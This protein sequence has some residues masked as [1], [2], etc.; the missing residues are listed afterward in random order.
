M[1]TRTDRVEFFPPQQAGLV[2][3]FGLAL[4]AHGLLLLALTWGVNWKRQ[5][6]D[7]VAEAEL[8][9]AIPQQAAPRPAPPPEP[10][11]EPPAPVPSPAPVPEP[12]PPAPAPAPEPAP[13][14]ADIALEQIKQKQLR[15]EALAREAALKAQQERKLKAEQVAKREAEQRQIAQQK[16]LLDKA[17]ADKA[18]EEKRKLQAT[19][20]SA[21]QAKQDAAKL[22]KEREEQLRRIMSQ[23]G[24]VASPGTGAQSATGTAPRSSGPSDSYEARVQAKL[25]PNIVF[26]DNI[27]GNPLADVEVRAA[28]DGTI[29]ARRLVRSSGNPA[30]DEA[31]LKAIDKTEV[32]PKDVDGRVPS[33]LLIGIR[34]KK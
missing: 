31:V 22:A 11:P 8:W 3:G 7:S 28:P 17:L 19:T 29:T 15:E 20:Q 26:T 12:A 25:Y 6:Q 10:A 4:L 2:R 33:P 14:P 16:A 1:P 13:P 30:W 32:L 9:S 23:A 27:S 34:P 24:A 21:T 5:T 18:L